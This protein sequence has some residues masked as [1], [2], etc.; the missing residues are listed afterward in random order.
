MSKRNTNSAPDILRRAVLSWLTAALTEFLLLPKELRALEGLEGLAGMSFARIMLIFCG[1]FA[2]L[3]VTSFFVHAKRAERWGIA[4]VCALLAC[5]A[6]T[7]SFTWAFLAACA[8]ILAL[9]L[10]Y[11]AL[12]WDA[13]PE[14]A[15]EP[16]KAHRAWGWVTAGLTAAF[17]LF[18]SAWT[19]GRYASFSSPTYD[20]GIFSQMF[21]SMKTTGLPLTTLERD[22]ALSHFAVHVSPV[23]YLMLPLYMLFPAPAVLQV[24]QAAV[25]A[26]AVIPLWLLGRHHGLSGAQ[27]TLIC[28]VLLLYP[29]FSGG[30]GY[31]LHENC[32]LT[33][34][35]LWLFYGIDRKNAVLTALAAVLTL[36]VK[37]DAAVYVAV[38]GL[39]LTVRTVLRFRGKEARGLVTGLALLGAAL[40][41]FT[42]VTGYLAKSGDGVMTYRYDNFMYDGSS[43]LVTV[44]KAVILSPLKAVYECVDAEKLGFIAM[45]LLPLLGLP[46]LTRR[47]ERYIL[48]IPYLLVNLMSDYRYQH[49]ILFQYTFGTTAFLMYLTVVNSAELKIDWQRL[50]GL[51]GAAAVS[52]VYFAGAVVPVAVSYPARAVRY[53]AY[54]QNI[55][56]TLDRIPADASVSATTFYTAHLS[57][58]PVLYDVR[59]GSKEHLLETE[60]IVLRLNA[61]HEYRKYE[62]G[63]KEN[64]LENLI[65]LLEGQGYG[66]FARVDGELVIYFMP[67]RS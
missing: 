43:S 47:Y 42:L 15:A 9:L 28:A 57:R 63:G 8:L 33:P 5:A 60:Y 6:L 48:L 27:R 38:T 14:P 16:R 67:H 61:A 31:D 25:I 44:I 21:Y 40:G 26:S 65:K 41:W 29:A 53:H 51:A 32:F 1:V 58:R 66:E 22:G 13:S 35:L 55:R 64:G 59:Y 2:L 46:L 56:D 62:T 7:A 49:D 36:S 45:T 3:T 24:L 52:A 50:L 19:V 4:A 34:L 54:Y 37:E 39:W 12:G 11:G 23:Y 30:T 20:F 10:L 17:F 18:V